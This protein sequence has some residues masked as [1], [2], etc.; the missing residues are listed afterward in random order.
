MALKRFITYLRYYDW[1]M[2]FS[3][4]L[5]LSFGLAAL[6]GIA[7]GFDSPDF[8]N[9]KKQ[10]AFACIGLS[11]LIILSFLD[12]NIFSSYAYV[13]YTVIG[14]LLVSVLVFGVTLRGTTGWLTFFGF[15]FQPVELAKFSLLIV[16]A[17]IFSNRPKEERD[18]KFL[19]HTGI[20]ALIYFILVLLQPDFGSA[21]LLFFMWLGFVL[22]SGVKKTYL[23][24]L[25]FMM[26]IGFIIAWSFFFQ[27]Y[28]KNR[29]MT[30]FNPTADPL[31][32]GYHVRQSIIAIG[33]GS[34]FG[35]GLASGSQSQLKFI[36]ASQTDFI[37]AVISEEL[38]FLGAFLVLSL[39]ASFFYRLIRIA[40]KTHDDFALHLVLGIS[41]LF[42]VQFIINV[43]MNVGIMPVTGISLPFLSYGGSFLIISFIFVGIVESIVI[44][45][46]KYKI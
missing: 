18:L 7:T 2:L 41:I 44:R 27:D 33:S 20:I 22:F 31:G 6:Y 4:I 23:L 16:L 35:K 3:V 19:I 40:K 11:F 46:V 34:L 24:S 28:Q 12:Y 29:V 8:S 21:M 17:K 37:F 9:L 26:L 10:I 30:F 45:T 14:I 39:Y 42:F 15:N 32:S 36:P 13:L 38:G 43:G 5:L 1:I 25:L